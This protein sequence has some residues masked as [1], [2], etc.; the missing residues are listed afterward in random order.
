MKKRALSLLLVLVLLLGLLP[1]AA[2]AEDAE[3]PPLAL[4]RFSLSACGITL[5]DT[6]AGTGGYS[7]SKLTYEF[8]AVF[9]S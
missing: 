4:S 9:V 8:D 5:I 1:T 3:T 7:S 6:D 2:L